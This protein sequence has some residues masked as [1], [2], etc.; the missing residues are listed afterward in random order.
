MP[1][2]HAYV[3]AGAHACVRGHDDNSDAGSVLEK[4]EPG[5]ARACTLKG[6]PDTDAQADSQALQKRVQQPDESQLKG[7]TQSMTAVR[8]PYACTL[9]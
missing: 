6:C 1:V 3:H 5:F 9:Q 4:L 8:Q 2:D 7:C